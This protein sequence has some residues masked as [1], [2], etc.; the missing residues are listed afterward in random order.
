MDV[1]L[2]QNHSTGLYWSRTKTVSDSSRPIPLNSATAKKRQ[3][4]QQMPQLHAG[5][6]L[7]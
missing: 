6:F 7:R 3:Y 1:A 2:C 5:K 4:S